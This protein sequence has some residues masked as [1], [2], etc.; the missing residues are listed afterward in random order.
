[1][2][3]ARQCEFISIPLL[4]VFQFNLIEL[5]TEFYSLIQNFK[6][7]SQLVLYW[8]RLIAIQ[9]Q[10]GLFSKSQKDFS[11]ITDPAERLRI[12]LP[13]DF[14]QSLTFIPRRSSH[15]FLLLYPLLY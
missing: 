14:R 3:H 10:G 6:H 8:S 1:M 13:A 15:Y 9:G 2:L 7:L 12:T 5:I 4:H 11:I